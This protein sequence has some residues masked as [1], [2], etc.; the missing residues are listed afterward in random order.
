ME[1]SG[2][3][4]GQSLASSKVMVRTLIRLSPGLITVGFSS[5]Y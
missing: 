3:K 4:K 2:D 5:Y 1:R